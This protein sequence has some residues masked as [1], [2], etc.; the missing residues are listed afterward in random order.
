[1][2]KDLHKV[3]DNILNGSLSMGWASE[4]EVVTI[5]M[6]FAQAFDNFK[7]SL[8][9]PSVASEAQELPPLPEPLEIDWPTLNSNAL[10]CGVEDRN[11][12]N[13]YECAEYGWQDGVDRAIERVPEAIYDADQMRDYGRAILAN[14]APNKA[15]VEALQECSRLESAEEIRSITRAALAAAGVKP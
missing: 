10:G 2:S 13:R 11:L 3:L 9:A 4:G 5:R 6:A 8:A 7:K 1:M 14:S 12:H 15:L